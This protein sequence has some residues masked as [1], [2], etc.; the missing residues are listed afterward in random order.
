L[1]ASTKLASILD[2][3]RAATRLLSGR[4]AAAE[5]AIHLSD[6]QLQHPLTSSDI[7][8]PSERVGGGQDAVGVDAR[9]A[10]QPVPDDRRQVEQNRLQCPQNEVARVRTRGQSKKSSIAGC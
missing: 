2:A 3:F 8:K 7:I 5:E 1:P 6:E 4:S 10:V 9:L